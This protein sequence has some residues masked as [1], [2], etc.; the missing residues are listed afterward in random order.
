MENAKDLYSLQDFDCTEVGGH[1][2]GRNRIFVFSNGDGEKFVLRVSALGDRTEQ[3]YL[4]E[5]EFVHYL[6]AGGAAV[7]DVITSVNGRLVE[8]VGA[9][10][11]SEARSSE[12]SDNASDSS[13]A[14]GACDSSIA[15]V[16][17][18]LFEY[19]KGM[20]LCNNGYR[21]RDGAPLEE[22]FY[23][24]GKTLGKI[25]AL[26]KRFAPAKQNC[27]RASYFDKYN[28][29][30]IESLIPDEYADLKNAIA[31]RFSEFQK[32]PT[33]SE[34]F[35]L[36]HFD[37]SDGNYHI[38]MK[39]GDITV[40]DFDNCMYCWYM[41]DLA[42]LWTHGE[43]WCRYEPDAAKRDAFM[44]H[45]FDT[46]LEGYRSETPVAESLVEKLPLFI[47]MVLIEN[48][49]DEFECCAREDEDVDYEDI[50][51]A[52]EWLLKN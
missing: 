34:S 29:D 20:L 47:D 48:I 36:V 50:K 6:A 45:Y 43:G 13:D 2:G 52:A 25:H 26:S 46:I 10:D 11:S 44:K 31:A 27:R 35:G 39:N 37:Y 15:P 12:D 21:Y 9:D 1:E 38:D 22:Y 7:A 42:N 33:D 3:E 17:I 14:R 16:F 28:M 51:G 24:T 23:N 18:S 32:L 49:V 8:V 4:A 19:A 41:F 40:F 30:Y 5:T